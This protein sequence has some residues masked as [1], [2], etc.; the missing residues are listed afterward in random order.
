MS[1]NDESVYEV[2][3]SLPIDYSRVEA[4]RDITFEAQLLL[5][6]KFVKKIT[7]RFDDFKKL[8]DLIGNKNSLLITEI[9]DNRFIIYIE[10]GLIVS[11]AMSNPVKG[12]RIVGLK[13]L[14]TLITI[15]KEQ[16]LVFKVF[17]IIEKKEDITLETPVK[18]VTSLVENKISA[19]VKPI[20]R[21][22]RFVKPVEEKPLIIVFAERI[23]EFMNKA[24]KIIAELVSVHGCKLVDYKMSISRE[25]ITLNIILKK[26]SMWTKC[27]VDELKNS[28]K[29]DL[30]LILTMLDINLPIDIRVEFRE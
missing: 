10:K 21:E 4:L 1:I 25:T 19:S 23:R 26:K 15:S 5:K 9:S 29:N 30:E 11:T 13:P 16:P 3:A 24:E 20:V 14:A 6:S 27:R 8:I 7:C 2:I 22:E 12:E 17:E 18:Q 28:L